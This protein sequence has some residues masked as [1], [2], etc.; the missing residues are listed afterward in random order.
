MRT[1]PTG[2]TAEWGLKLRALGLRGGASDVFLGLSPF[3]RVALVH[4]GLAIEIGSRGS[5]I[6][7][8]LATNPSHL[9][10]SHSV[11]DLVACLTSSLS[12]RIKEI[13]RFERFGSECSG[14]IDS[15]VVSALCNEHAEFIGATCASFPYFEFRAEK[16]FVHAISEHAG[17]NVFYPAPENYVYWSMLRAP[18]RIPLEPSHLLS[19]VGQCFGSFEGFSA[20]GLAPKAIITGHGGDLFFSMGEIEVECRPEEARKLIDTD[21]ET[22]LYWRLLI[23]DFRSEQAYLTSSLDYDNPWMSNVL[24]GAT[25]ATYE[26][27][28]SDPESIVLVSL[29]KQKLFKWRFDR[30]VQKPVA[31][32][33]FSHLLPDRVWRRRWKVSH[34]GLMYR[35]FM[36]NGE[37]IWQMYKSLRLELVEIGFRDTAFS[38]A[39]RGAIRGKNAADSELI[40]M[41]TFVVWLWRVRNVKVPTSCRFR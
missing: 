28:F 40:L 5:R 29:L 18:E 32:L 35:A 16:G 31:H 11:G 37:M 20:N 25:G 33:I 7:S 22:L 38:E 10:S 39:L 27:L 24:F 30:S 26:S 3:L 17:F 12:R 19:S 14:G 41:A 1:P 36:R 21:S 2:S 8:N 6:F 4:R 34:S 9:D 13:T 23:N 15:G